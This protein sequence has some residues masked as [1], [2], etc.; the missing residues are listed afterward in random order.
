MAS[1]ANLSVPW[2]MS[3]GTVS[4]AVRTATSSWVLK[5]CLSLSI[6][7]KL[8]TKVHELMVVAATCGLI[9]LKSACASIQSEQSSLSA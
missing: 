1:Q 5:V 2:H 9:R 8:Q 3:E 4:P 7:S 6:E